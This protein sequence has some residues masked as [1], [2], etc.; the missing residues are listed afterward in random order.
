LEEKDTFRSLTLATQVGVMVV[1][2]I[3]VCLFLG[4]WIDGKLHTSPWAT[5]ILL[6]V[7]TLVAIVGAYRLVYPIVE[8]VTVEQKAEMPTGAILRS[9]ALITRLGLMA[10]SPVLIGL[11]LG[12]WLDGRLQTRPWV[13]LFLTALG[14]LVGLVGVYRL[15]SSLTERLTEGSKKGNL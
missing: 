4:L 11:F 6:A 10:V 1:G 13:T 7:G 14:I 3:L 9:L 2:S 15:S 5:L 8:Q 12:L